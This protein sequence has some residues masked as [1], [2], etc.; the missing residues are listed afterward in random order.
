MDP[1]V[2]R[3]LAGIVQSKQKIFP[4]NR[5]R[6]QQLGTLL[7]YN[8]VRPAH[9]LRRKGY[10]DDIEALRSPQFLFGFAAEILGSHYAQTED[11]EMHRAGENRL[12]TGQCHRRSKKNLP[13]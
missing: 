13:T 11:R 3:Y 10:V 4:G 8:T 6:T 2:P 5:I 1:N 9:R 7:R 12:E